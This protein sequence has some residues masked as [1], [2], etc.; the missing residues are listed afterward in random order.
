MDAYSTWVRIFIILCLWM[1]LIWSHICIILVPVDAYFI[2][3]HLCI[4]VVPMDAYVIWIHK[5]NC[6]A[7][8]DVTWM[9]ICIIVVPMDA[10]VIWMHKGI[11]LVPM[12]AYFIW[13]IYTLFWYLW[14]HMLFGF[15]Y[16]FSS[17]SMHAL[18][19]FADA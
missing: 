14:M 6:L 12:D 5:C 17:T 18:H 15:I 13:F 7:P 16:A 2:W 1:Q 10:Y 8:A 19:G 9:H 11:I 3:T 4:I